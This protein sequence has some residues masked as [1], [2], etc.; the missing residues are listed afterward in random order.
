MKALPSFGGYTS[1]KAIADN[2]DVVGEADEVHH[3]RSQ[4]VLWRNRKL[5]DLGSLRGGQGG[6]FAIN[7]DEQIVGESETNARG[8]E[9]AFL[10]HLDPKKGV[11]CYGRNGFR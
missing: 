9:H 1:A 5:I 2:G 4:P 10:R 7:E 11:C 6:A 8:Q 3:A